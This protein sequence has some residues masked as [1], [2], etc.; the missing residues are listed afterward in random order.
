MEY[1]Y[2]DYEFYASII[3]KAISYDA[4]R[5]FEIA[6]SKID[7][8][9]IDVKGIVNID[10]Y[11][12]SRLINKIDEINDEFKSS[13]LMSL[14]QCS[15]SKAENSN[16]L[17]IVTAPSEILISIKILNSSNNDCCLDEIILTSGEYT[18]SI[19]KD[20]CE[21]AIINKLRNF[22]STRYE[23][24]IRKNISEEWCKN[25]NRELSTS[26]YK[27][28][29]DVHVKPLKNGKFYS[30]VLTSELADKIILKNIAK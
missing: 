29:R 26:L 23:I 25:A 11:V 4:V 3:Y 18:K 27:C 15:I 22:S 16:D 13:N 24:S 8:N 20:M 19:I 7:L 10:I 9:T 14:R 28:I 21:Y 6:S 1:N 17:L 30:V 2:I 5:L 12:L